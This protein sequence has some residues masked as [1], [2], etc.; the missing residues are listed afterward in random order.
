MV[1]DYDD[2]EEMDDEEF[3]REMEEERKRKANLPIVKKAKEIFR[4][5]HSL[6]STIDYEKDTMAYRD[7][8]FEDIAIINAKISGAEAVD[9]Y[10]LKMENAVLIK[11]HACSIISTTS[12]MKMM[13]LGHEDY[14]NVLRDEM[15]EFRKLF[16]DWIATFDKTNDIPDDWGLFY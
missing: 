7:I 11:I 4:T 3:E 15:E 2:F 1:F 13:N 6:I 16:V 12:G 5:V 10:S 9:L 8:L 14:L